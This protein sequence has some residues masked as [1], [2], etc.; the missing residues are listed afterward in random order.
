MRHR[1]LGCLVTLALSLCTTALAAAA[2][3]PTKVHRIGWL[4]AGPPLLEPNPSLEAF[5]QGLH[6]LGYVEGQNLVMEY[7]Y[8]EGRAERLPDLAAEL[9]R[10]QV[11]VIVAGGTAA[12]RA[13]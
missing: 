5:R 11:D 6:D 8:G 7:R 1:A 3:A 10:L 13:A 12:I 4:E 9:V 2:Q